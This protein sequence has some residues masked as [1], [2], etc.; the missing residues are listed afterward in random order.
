MLNDSV[1]SK[2]LISTGTRRFVLCLLR[3]GLVQLTTTAPFQAQRTP[4]RVIHRVV[5]ACLVKLK[6]SE[7]RKINLA[8]PLTHAAAY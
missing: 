6:L 2:D 4:L 8:Q 3:D 1:A 7:T 5:V